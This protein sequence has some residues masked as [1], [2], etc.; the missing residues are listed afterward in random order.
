[1][2]LLSLQIIPRLLVQHIQSVI[3]LR[4]ATAWFDRIFISSCHSGDSGAA[5]GS[6]KVDAAYHEHSAEYRATCYQ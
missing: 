6:P 3:H 1:M 5:Y 4:I 2:L